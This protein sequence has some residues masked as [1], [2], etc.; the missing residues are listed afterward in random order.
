MRALR[1]SPD[2]EL[3]A[4]GAAAFSDRLLHLVDARTLEPVNPQPAG[5]PKGN[6]HLMD[7]KF[8]QDS[9]TLA[10]VVGRLIRNGTAWENAGP[11][12]YVWSLGS[13]ARPQ[14][15]DLAPWSTG[16]ASAALS[17]DGSRLYSAS[18][19]L[20]VHDLQTGEV[21]TLWE[22]QGQTRYEVTVE[23][24][25]DGE[26][27]VL[28]RGDLDT[29]ALVL[30]ATTGRVLHTLPHTSE[31]FE[32]RFSDDG[33]RLLTVT[34]RP[35]AAFM[36][37]TSTGKRL[38]QFELPLGESGAVDLSGDG[39]RVMSATN[40]AFVI[41]TSTALVDMCAETRSRDCHR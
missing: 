18:P 3:I 8:S 14:M 32:A 4:A 15:I 23:A 21:R 37:D 29:G 28:A 2:G 27:L 20:R 13:M 7:A 25:P 41:W 9:S 24:S 30:D 17:P 38:A 40:M 34:Y 1:I 12:V 39:S 35:T 26:L 11:R 5:L 36:W 33:R 31:A 6:W 22:E 19:T 10:V 16:W